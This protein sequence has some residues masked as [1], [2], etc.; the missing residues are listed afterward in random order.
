L[1]DNGV[2]IVL[3][4][5]DGRGASDGVEDQ[6]GA[7]HQ[8]GLGAVLDFAASLPCAD[9][10][11]LGLYSSSFGITMASGVLA[12]DPDSPA[13]FLVD[14]EGPASRDDTAGCDGTPV[15]H[16]QEVDCDDEAFWEY[17]EAST[18]MARVA[19]P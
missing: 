9:T 10:R 18:S 3:F 16:L 19:V 11:R 1:S 2:L 15:G 7:V 8:A 6:G 4:D 17:R 5:P 13:K 12:N 14:W